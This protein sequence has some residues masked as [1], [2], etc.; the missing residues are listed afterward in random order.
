MWNVIRK[1]SLRCKIC[2]RLRLK[3]ISFK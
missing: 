1:K 3:W 2:F